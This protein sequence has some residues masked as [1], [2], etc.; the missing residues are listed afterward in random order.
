MN[1]PPVGFKI[2]THEIDSP[3]GRV[4]V[5]ALTQEAADWAKLAL[6]S[7]Q[8]LVRA[9]NNAISSLEYVDRASPELVGYIVRDERIKA[10]RA[11]L[12]KVLP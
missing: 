5:G 10:G 3:V 9:L 4:N 2:Y 1:T 6:E 8:D 11:I 12:A 7:H